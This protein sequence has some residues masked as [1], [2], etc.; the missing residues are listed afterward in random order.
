MM[1]VSASY[2][3]GAASVALGSGVVHGEGV[4]VGIFGGFCLVFSI[5]AFIRSTFP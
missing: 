4:G 2:F 1:V 3:V 5:A